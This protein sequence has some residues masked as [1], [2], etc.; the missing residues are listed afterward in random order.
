MRDTRQGEIT[1]LLHRWEEGEP[2]AIEE[3]APL[4]YD[5][6][7]GIAEWL[8]RGGKTDQERAG[9]LSRALAASTEREIFAG[10]RAALMT[11][12]GAR[13]ARLAT[14]AERSGRRRNPVR[15]RLQSGPFPKFPRRLPA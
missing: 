3:L 5:Q 9:K 7:R 13:P 12:E 10:L 2:G 14:K 6:L 11:A 8:S 1:E 4:V 15:R